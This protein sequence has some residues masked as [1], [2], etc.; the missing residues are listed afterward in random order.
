MKYFS[1]LVSSLFVAFLLL[2]VSGYAIE[3]NYKI[4]TPN[5]HTHYVQVEM[6]VTNFKGSEMDVKMPV[7]A[8]GSYLVREFAKSVEGFKAHTGSKELEVKKVNKNT[9]RIYKG[10]K[11]KATIKYKVYAFELSVRTSYVDVDHA[12]FN[13]TSVFMY[14]KDE[15]DASG[16]LTIVPY[17]NWKKVN[18]G[19]A[20]KD[21][22]EWVR[23]YPNYDI[24]VDS[25][26]EIGNQLTFDFMAA[27]VKHTVAMFGEGNFDI[28]KL[29][30]D[31]ARIVETTTD[32]FGFNPNKEYTFIIHN[33]TNGSGGLEHLNSTT[34][35]VNRWTYE[36]SKYEGFLSLV[37]HEYFHLWNVKRIRPINLGPF[38]YDG[39]NYTPLLWIMEGFTSYYDE[40]ILQRS[41][42]YS[43]DTYLRK[44]AG[45]ATRVENQPGNKVLPVAESSLDAWVKLYRPNE[46]SYN[47]TISY[48]SKGSLVAMILDLEIIN[49]TNAEKSLDDVLIYLYKEY[50][51]KKGRGFTPEE[52][53]TAIE[54]V[55]G[56]KL[57]EI[58][59]RYINGTETIDYAKYFGY[60]GLNVVD[61]NASKNKASFGVFTKKEDGKL[62][63]STV[64]RNTT[65]Y[66][67]KISV[68][69]EIIAINGMRVTKSSLSSVFDMFA[70]GEEIEVLVSRDGLLRTLTMTVKNDPSVRY[71]LE[72]EEEMSDAQRKVFEKW[73][74]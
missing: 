37:A 29:K 55:A 14:V 49:S 35:Q 44:M 73:L 62:I 52:A 7:W 33:L 3:V 20:K 58:F 23:S 54:H 4:S 43:K 72:A 66:E 2:S 13:G 67:G 12:Y 1:S 34:L 60:A 48:Y 38:N 22:S 71:V 25:P 11:D 30:K 40:L 45:T 63:V 36:G 32:I 50:Y 28:E 5:P 21:G 15:L 16:I 18:T 9:W 19:L 65:A 39:E 27:G 17:Q 31:M 56:K 64:V 46:N 26:I 6:E 8:P 59:D 74:R 42:D 41:G 53:R 61:A 47:T 69:D 70:V 68:N 51:E 10:K 57:D 24:L